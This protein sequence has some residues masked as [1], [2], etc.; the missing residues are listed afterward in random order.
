MT[1]FDF[2]IDFCLCA[3][4]FFLQ[5]EFSAKDPSTYFHYS[6][7]SDCPQMMIDVRILTALAEGSG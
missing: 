7:F 2:P 1:Y 3:W 5:R 4:L 6:C